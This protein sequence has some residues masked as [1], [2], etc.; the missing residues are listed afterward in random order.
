[1][2]TQET[3]RRVEQN[4]PTLKQLCIGD[5][6]V[7]GGFAVTSAVSSFSRLG[8]CIVDNTHIERLYFICL[9]SS[10]TTIIESGF[11]EG[12]NRNSSISLLQLNLLDQDG[13]HELEHALL[14]AYQEDNS[15][16]QLVI[17]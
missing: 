5:S 3:L 17:L 4:D 1:M 11:I 16:R 14:N 12:L 15:N 2:H 9:P 13:G 10:A 7:E 8:E 6:D